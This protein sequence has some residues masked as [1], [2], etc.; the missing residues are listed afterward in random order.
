MYIF[1]IGTSS[2]Y[3]FDIPIVFFTKTDLSGAKTLEEVAACLKANG[4]PNVSYKAQTHGDEPASS[5]GALAVMKR[6]D[7]AEYAHLLD[8]INIYVIPRLNPDGAYDCKRNLSVMI[9]PSLDNRDPDRDLMDMNSREMRQY[10]YIADLFSP[11]IALDGHE[12]GHSSDK[13]EIQLGIAWKPI[14][15]QALL[16][17]QVDMMQTA[18]ELIENKEKIALME[19]NIA[20]L[21]KT[22][23]AMTIAEEVY[24]YV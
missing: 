24:K 16:D 14:N 6:L 17:A 12:L 20:A 5:E 8:S 7:S 4:K 11:I 21:A 3:G 2:K 18:C 10:M 9:D 19:K 1:S 22:D 13:G 23:A 15:G